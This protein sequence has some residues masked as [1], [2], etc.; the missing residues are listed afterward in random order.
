MMW[1][2]TAQRLIDHIKQ[3][4]KDKEALNSKMDRNHDENKE[5]LNKIVNAVDKLLTGADVAAGREAER[6][7]HRGETWRRWAVF[8]TI[9]AAVVALYADKIFKF[10]EPR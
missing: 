1:G 6:D 8:A 2:G 9:G 3:C 7:R 4:E 5:S 10:L